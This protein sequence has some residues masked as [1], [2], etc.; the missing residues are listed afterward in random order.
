MALAIR[1]MWILFGSSYRVPRNV[2]TLGGPK[3]AL[4]F[5]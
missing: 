1:G 4:F 3:A 2:K 5:I